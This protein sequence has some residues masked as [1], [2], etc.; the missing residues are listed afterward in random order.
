MSMKDDNRMSSRVNLECAIKDYFDACNRADYPF[1]DD[2]SDVVYDG[3]NGSFT[4]EVKMKENI[5]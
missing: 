1:E 2:L 5:L 3:T 4:V